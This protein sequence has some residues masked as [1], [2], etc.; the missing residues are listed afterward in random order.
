M[1]EPT[2]QDRERAARLWCLPQHSH[3]EMDADFAES[4][5]AEFAAVRAGATEAERDRCWREWDEVQL[6][7][8]HDAAC[9]Y[10]CTANGCHEGHPA[11]EVLVLA[12]RRYDT[13]DQAEAAHND[14]AAAIR[15]GK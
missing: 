10:S 9:G 5:A 8:P 14:I 15:R 4:V 6:I 2:T 13:E 12:L 1:T 3:K 7:D 11:G